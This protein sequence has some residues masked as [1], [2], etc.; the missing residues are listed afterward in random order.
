MNIT[1]Y[2][3]YIK[4][5]E[6]LSIGNCIELIALKANLSPKTIEHYYYNRRNPT[7]RN[8]VKLIALSDYKIKFECVMRRELAAA[9]KVIFRE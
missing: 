3:D 6:K 5:R 9:Q 2:I 4:N 7:T 1:E 8:M